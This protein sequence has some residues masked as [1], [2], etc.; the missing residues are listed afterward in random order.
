MFQKKWINL[1]WTFT[2]D[3]FANLTPK[4]DGTIT[5]TT[6]ALKLTKRAIKIIAETTTGTITEA[7]TEATA[8]LTY[9]YEQ[10]MIFTKKFPPTLDIPLCK[11]QNISAGSL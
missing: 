11:V 1:F 2:T 10:K 6:E 7:I 5:K 3:I 4:K 8:R 9:L